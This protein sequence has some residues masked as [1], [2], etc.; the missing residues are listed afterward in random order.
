MSEKATL[1]ETGHGQAQL[2]FG[3]LQVRKPVIGLGFAQGEAVQAE[4]FGSKRAQWTASKCRMPAR[5]PVTE[6]GPSGTRKD[7]GRQALPK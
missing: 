3:F 1:A 4:S 7:I 6:R 5:A 2:V